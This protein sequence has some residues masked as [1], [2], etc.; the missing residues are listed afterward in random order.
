MSEGVLLKNLVKVLSGTVIAQLIPLMFLP[1]L[2]RIYTVEEFGGFSF[3]FIMTTT[4]SI[5]VTARYEM[6]VMLPKS[7]RIA[8]ALTHSAL[9]LSLFISVLLT[10][11]VFL[12]ECII[13]FEY[14]YFVILS[15][16]FFGAFNLSIAWL[17]RL[18]H[19]N[20]LALLMVTQQLLIA[21][22]KV[23][24]FDLWSEGNPLVVGHTFG[25]VL[26]ALISI[27]FLLKTFNANTS[28][29]QKL[30]SRAYYKKKYI[31]IPFAVIRKYKK[32]PMYNL[33]FSL[34]VAFS[35]GFII[36]ILIVYGFTAVAGLVGLSRTLVYAPVS[37]L[38]RSLGKVFY[39]YAAKKFN[40]IDDDIEGLV[41]N[42]IYHLAAILTPFFCL[43]L[44]TSE[45]LLTQLL[46]E[47]WEGIGY[48]AS[49]LSIV[50]FLLL[51]TTWP[52]RMFEVTG[53]QGLLLKFQIISDAIVMSIISI[54]FYIQLEVTYIINIYCLL[55]CTYNLTYLKLLAYVSNF[56]DGFFYRV[57]KVISIRFICVFSVFYFFNFFT[58]DESQSFFLLL[59]CAFIVSGAEAVKIKKSYN[60]KEVLD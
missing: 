55:A 30:N 5:I 21:L 15:A 41:F 45:F 58:E 33:P 29:A 50:A 51:L 6:A 7:D 37:I 23:F 42:G 14:I 56:N 1:Y 48:Y 11:F 49:R 3:Y 38:A 13:D 31:L 40:S 35:N 47:K 18:T 8:K 53:S 46:G 19:Y 59:V 54:V 25:L 4:V 44:L 12:L 27:A 57:I 16:F 43:F 9:I 60:I 36:T 26:S 17:N 28:S 10:L 2:S 22:F 39:Q 24:I 32:F 34:L 52:A 20:Y